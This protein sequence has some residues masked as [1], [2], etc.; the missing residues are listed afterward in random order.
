MQYYY[1]LLVYIVIVYCANID[2]LTG[3][4]CSV[5]ASVPMMLP[6]PLQ[7][8]TNST[9]TCRIDVLV[10]IIIIMYNVRGG[11]IICMVCRRRCSLG[12]SHFCGICPTGRRQ[13]F[14]STYTIY[15]NI[16][17]RTISSNHNVK[18]VTIMI[19]LNAKTLTPP[20]PPPSNRLTMTAAAETRTYLFVAL[21]T[22]LLLL[23][24]SVRVRHTRWTS[25]Y[26]LPTDYSYVTAQFL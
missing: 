10:I 24:F 11:S 16:L 15:Y 6:H 5:N 18:T 23:L 2:K 1:I 3:N 22:L 13:R 4:K 20:P 8:A 17:N 21:V 12:Y 7:V 14:I 25:L 19:N 9:G 26:T